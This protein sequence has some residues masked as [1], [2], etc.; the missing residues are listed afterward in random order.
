[1][2]QAV[3]TTLRQLGS[4]PA[5]ASV[6]TVLQ[7]ATK[8]GVVLEQ[9]YLMGKLAKHNLAIAGE[10]VSRYQSAVEYSNEMMKLEQRVHELDGQHKINVGRYK[11]DQAESKAFFAGHQ[12]QLKVAD[13]IF[14]GGD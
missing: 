9:N 8:H 5:G 3:K 1:V 12:R 14:G 10:L 6:S 2:N 11:L 7:R 4:L 13:R